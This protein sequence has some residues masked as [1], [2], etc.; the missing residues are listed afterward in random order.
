MII[1]YK[2]LFF[3]KRFGRHFSNLVIIVYIFFYY[4]GDIEIHSTS[5]LRRSLDDRIEFIDLVLIN[6]QNPLHN[7]INFV[8][9][10]NNLRV[11]LHLLEKSWTNVV[12]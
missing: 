6:M 8:L 12:L 2:K 9:L 7:V 4:Y 1:H 5:R 3:E 11:L 10:K